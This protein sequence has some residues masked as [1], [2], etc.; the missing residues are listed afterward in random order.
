MTLQKISSQPNIDFYTPKVELD[1]DRL[2]VNVKAGFPSPAE[3][4]LEAKISL[5]KELVK[6]PTS[7]FYGRVNGKSMIDAGLDDG[8]V[9]VIDRSIKPSTDS[10]ALCC[11][12]GEFTVKKIKM[13]GETCFL[14]PANIKFKPIEVKIGETLIIWGVVTYIIK[15]V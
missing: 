11:I 15:K 3:D 14:M 4:F 6:N 1:M 12:E 2:I 13:E 5:D 9:I 7:T 10:I 8:D